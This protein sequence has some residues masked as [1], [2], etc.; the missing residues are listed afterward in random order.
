MARF[1]SRRKRKAMTIERFEDTEAGRALLSAQ[2][3]AHEQ[4]RAAERGQRFDPQLEAA[5]HALALKV[6][7]VRE[8]KRPAT[9]AEMEA[10]IAGRQRSVEYW[11]QELSAAGRNPEKRKDCLAALEKAQTW[12]DECQTWRDDPAAMAEYERKH[13]R[14]ARE[15]GECEHNVE[16][17]AAGA[18]ARM[19]SRRERAAAREQVGLPAEDGDLPALQAEAVAIDEQVSAARKAYAQSIQPALNEQREA[20]AGRMR[21][22]L[23]EAQSASK[24][25]IEIEAEMRQHGIALEGSLV[26]RELQ[27][28][29]NSDAL[30]AAAAVHQSY[31]P[32]KR[33]VRS[34]VGR[35]EMY[36]GTQIAA[37]RRR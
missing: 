14:L 24:R 21:S 33:D 6:N 34:L 36:L 20:E 18:I 5:R 32:W 37:A 26:P 31:E 11:Q 10:S 3:H 1:W 35:L 2:A 28:D 17:A 30:M 8:L 22:A 23:L 29:G 16:R 9:R 27:L 25:V 7:E 15:L 4:V 19:K 12:L 13:D